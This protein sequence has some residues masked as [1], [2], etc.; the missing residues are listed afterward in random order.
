MSDAP[1]PTSP[2][3]DAGQ[4]RNVRLAAVVTLLILASPFAVLVIQETLAPVLAVIL[5]LVL[6]GPYIVLVLRLLRPRQGAFRQA[7]GAGLAGLLLSGLLAA[8]ILTLTFSPGDG[9]RKWELWALLGGYS[10][11]AWIQ[12]VLYRNARRIQESL[13][14]ELSQ[15]PKWGGSTVLHFVYYFAL[16]LLM[17]VAVPSLIRSPMAANEVTAIGALRSLQ[18]AARTYQEQF[19]NG[20]PA[21][22]ATLLPLPRGT[23]ASCTAADLIDH[24]LAS[25][26]KSGYRIEYRPGPAI[27]DPPAGCPPGVKSYTITV[28]P[29]RYGETGMRSF[30]TDE[31]RVIRSTGDDRA[32]TT[33]DPPIL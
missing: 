27:E 26:Q 30:F 24:S 3:P 14:L 6:A 33:A 23:Q 12:W 18:V 31:T 29:L 5:A 10:F 7:E 25:G 32:A 21:S 9:W 4:L 20:Y 28:Q 16:L 1:S 17:G 8:L 22:L 13:W 15:K 19:K 11:L 2:T